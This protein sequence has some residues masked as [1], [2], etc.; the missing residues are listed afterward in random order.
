MRSDRVVVLAPLLDNNG[1]FLQAVEDLPIE[2]FIAQFSVKGLAVA[3]L[4]GTAGFD[5]KCLRS[6]FGKPAAHDLCCHLRAVVRANVFRD[7]LGEHHIGHRLND[8]KAIDPASHPDR[9]ALPGELVDQRHQS[10]LSSIMGLRF[11]EVVAPHM[12]AMLRPQPDTRPVIEPK[13][14]P[15]LLLPWYF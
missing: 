13:P 3:V 10:E 15:R 1:G 8:A 14:A 11:D 4:P 7:A 12:I 9:K 6:K 5:V 2:Q